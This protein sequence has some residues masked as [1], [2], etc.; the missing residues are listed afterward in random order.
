MSNRIALF[1]RKSEIEDFF[2]V[3]IPEDSLVAPRY[4]IAP[5]QQILTLRMEEKEIVPQMKRWGLSVDEKKPE[6]AIGKDEALEGLRKGEFGRCVIPVSGYYK[7]K[8]SGKRADFPFYIRM[9]HEPLMAL[10]GIYDRRERDGGCAI[11]RV[12]ANPLIQ[13]L[14]PV[15]PLQ[16]N[17][18]LAREWLAGEREAAELI[19][20]AGSVY[21]M[22]EMTVLRVSNRVNDLS[23][24]SPDLIQPLPK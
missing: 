22:T 3:R 6:Q 1:N 20:D 2:Q 7:W 24:D 23:Q 4:N 18:E 12:D 21:L 5:G 15:M 9:L 16:F 17:S 10:A 14:D 13:P 11:I 8:D 19:E